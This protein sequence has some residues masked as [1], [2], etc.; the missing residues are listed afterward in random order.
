MRP[1][2][3]GRKLVDDRRIEGVLALLA[4]FDVAVLPA[5]I[6]EEVAWRPLPVRAAP[7]AAFGDGIGPQLHHLSAFR[8][9][10]FG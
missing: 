10:G 7:A 9:S 2:R 6:A 8:S 5:A 1:V 4:A 3:L